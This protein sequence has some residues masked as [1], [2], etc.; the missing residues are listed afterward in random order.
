MMDA[1]IDQAA[2]LV[3]AGKRKCQSTLINQSHEDRR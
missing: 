3:Y 1:N 2:N